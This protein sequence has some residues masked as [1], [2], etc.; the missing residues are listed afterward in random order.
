MGALKKT[1]WR[2]GRQYPLQLRHLGNI[3]LQEERAAIGIESAGEEIDRDT[4]AVF[5]QLIRIPHAGERVVIGD[6]IEG[7]AFGLQRDCGPNHP[8]IIANMEDATWLNARKNAH[9]SCRSER[10]RG[11]SSLQ[12]AE[13][14]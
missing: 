14:A 6:E 7:L 1:H 11:I 3:A 10:S 4:P 8:E 5:A 9:L 12:R 2:Y 13:T